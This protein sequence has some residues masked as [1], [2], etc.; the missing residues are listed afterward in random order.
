MMRVPRTAQ[1]TITRDSRP[2]RNDLRSAVIAAVV[3]LSAAATTAAAPDQTQ[4][5]TPAAPAKASPA[6][7]QPAQ[8]AAV[9]PEHIQVQHILIG[10]TGSV[11]GKPINRT[12][13]EARKLAYE[14]LERGKKGEDFDALVKQYTEDAYPGIYSMANNGVTPAQGE[15]PRNR[16][17]AA[18]GDTGFPLKVG[19]I[20]IADHD[21]QKSPYGYHIVKRLK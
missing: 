7:A 6:P 18:F 1:K 15:F 3:I 14:I 13:E 20:G 11:P 4:P 10:F 17:V 2:G 12:P 19:G 8:A 21:K 5:A 9:E 16:M